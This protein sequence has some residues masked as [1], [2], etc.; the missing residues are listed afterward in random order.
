M[1]K[2]TKYLSNFIFAGVVL[3]ATD[4]KIDIVAPTEFSALQGITFPGLIS[5]VI[6]AILVVAALIAFFYLLIGGIK[7]IT[8]GGDKEK[9]SAAQSTLTAAL[10]GLVIV[11]AAW[12][13]I[14]LV[15]TFFG[16][17][18]LGNLN[19]PVIPSTTR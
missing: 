14:N 16:I 4:Q 19:I 17:T 1:E 11:F 18:I 13:I 7:W 12:A 5:T 8:S 2:I 9:T 6:K 3:A 15:Q 10:V